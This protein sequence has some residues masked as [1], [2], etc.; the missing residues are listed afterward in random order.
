MNITFFGN[1][2]LGDGILGMLVAALTPTCTPSCSSEVE[3]GES[4]DDG[5]I[6]YAMAT[7]CAWF[8]AR[9]NNVL[10]RATLGIVSI[11]V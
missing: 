8:Q 7:A 4:P 1:M 11:E 9:V 10:V 5:C 6:H 2:R 3:V